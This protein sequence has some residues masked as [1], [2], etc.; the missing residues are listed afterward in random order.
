[1]ESKYE[2]SRRIRGCQ[3]GYNIPLCSSSRVL[4]DVRLVFFFSFFSLVIII[5]FYL[6]FLFFI[7]IFVLFCWCLREDLRKWFLSMETN[8][9]RYRLLFEKAEAQVGSAYSV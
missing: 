2:A 8:L 5:N 4:Q 7:F 6:C 9:F 1:M 3:Q